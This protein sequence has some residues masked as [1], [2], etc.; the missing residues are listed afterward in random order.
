MFRVQKHLALKL[1]IKI[2][3][4]N[5]PLSTFTNLK[6][7][8]MTKKHDKLQHFGLNDLITLNYGL[9]SSFTTQST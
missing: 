9:P 3:S 2:K 1:V 7:R 6:F 4:C 5:R 8:R